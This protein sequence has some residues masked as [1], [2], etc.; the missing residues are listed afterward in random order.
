M[1]RIR[2]IR[3]TQSHQDESH[4]GER[5][6]GGKTGGENVTV[7]IREDG[8]GRYSGRA[9]RRY[10][11]FSRLIDPLYRNP[12]TNPS[13]NTCAEPP[14]PFPSREQREHWNLPPPLTVVAPHWRCLRYRG[15]IHYIPACRWHLFPITGG[16]RH[17]TAKRV[18]DQLA[19]RLVV[20]VT[21]QRVSSRRKPTTGTLT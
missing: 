20:L 11:F 16:K 1:P 13:K 17:N 19:N 2:W 4:K 15:T 7:W 14:P 21:N 9:G 8:D 10:C 18:S 12:K 3:N 5:E 6:L